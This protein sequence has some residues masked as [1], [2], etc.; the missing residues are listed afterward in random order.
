MCACSQALQCFMFV[1]LVICNLLAS[2]SSFTTTQTKATNEQLTGPKDCFS[3]VDIWSICLLK[4]TFFVRWFWVIPD[5]IIC[6]K[7]NCSPGPSCGDLMWYK[8]AIP[9]CNSSSVPNRW[10]RPTQ[11]LLPCCSVMIVFSLFLQPPRQLLYFARRKKKT[12]STSC[13]HVALTLQSFHQH[14]IIPPK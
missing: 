10:P 14:P 13:H 7:P 5:N 2:L 12:L 11:F 4:T 9:G 6:S 1:Y 3:Y 8:H